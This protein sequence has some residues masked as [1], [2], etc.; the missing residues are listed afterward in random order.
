MNDGLDVMSVAQ[1]AESLGIDPDAIHRQSALGK[2]ELIRLG[3]R[4]VVIRR[5]E[6]ERYR[7]ENLGRRGRPRKE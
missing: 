4:T 5:E 1:A 6:V 3:P 2:I 7:R